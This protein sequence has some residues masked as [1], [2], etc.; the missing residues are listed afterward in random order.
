MKTLRLI[1]VALL[2]LI[3]TGPGIAHAQTLASPNVTAPLSEDGEQPGG[4]GDADDTGAGDTA[5]D[6]G[7]AGDGDTADDTGD[8]DDTGGSNTGDTGGNSGTNNQ[9]P[10]PPPLSLYELELS[11]RSTDSFGSWGGELPSTMEGNGYRLVGG[12]G[13]RGGQI[14][15]LLCATLSNGRLYWQNQPD[16][17][18]SVIGVINW[19]SSDPGVASVNTQGVVTALADG[20]VTITASAQGKSAEFY[21]RVFGQAGAYVT[22]A[23][24]CYEDGE[25]YGTTY[26]EYDTIDGSSTQFYLRVY[27]S[28][29]TTECN[30][31]SAE[32]F[33][34]ITATH[35]WSLSTAELGYIN[36]ATGNFIPQRDGQARIY[37]T[38][39][40]GDPAIS[41]G[42]VVDTVY[43]SVNTGE[44]EDGNMPSSN[45]TIRVV[46]QEDEAIEAR[47]PVSLTVAQLQAIQ[48]VQRTYTLTRS[49]QKHVTDSAT[50]IDLAELLASQNIAVEDIAHF[51]LAANDGANPG[52]I[53]ADFLFGHA[54]YYFPLIEW[55]STNEAVAV[56][57]ML[58][59]ADSWH[60]GG[61]PDEDY[62]SLNSGTCLRL[63]FG[64]TGLADDSTSWSI[65]YIHTLTVVLNG[66]P[67]Y[68]PGDDDG[69]GNGEG[70]GPGNGED[71]TGD[72]DDGEDGD[73]D[74]DDGQDG[75]GKAADDNSANEAGSNQDEQESDDPAAPTGDDDSGN[76]DPARQESPNA[77]EQLS[78]QDSLSGVALHELAGQQDQQQAAA[79]PSGPSEQL[80]DPSVPLA[81]L[82]AA[83]APLPGGSRW[84][85]FE[86]MNKLQTETEALSL[87]NPLE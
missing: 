60:D 32:D 22:A 56:P 58:A 85:V 65:K 61:S 34:T 26:V 80:V 71:D 47:E 59:Y 62:S 8:A 17:P 11:A 16:W 76:R 51:R 78:Q 75:A 33:K 43:V 40:G 10:D 73:G 66:G 64:S 9:D 70:E 25:E 49:N 39:T 46:W 6:T 42:Q 81:S 28:D 15:L 82:A 52:A 13:Q 77:S 21:I 86:M 31:P 20:D 48:N 4:S 55:G 74:K 57:A 37:A 72:K 41:G 19:Q 7:D 18:S 54:R 83:G 23:Q 29:G 38:V 5:D 44:S 68:E 3:M 50:G 53:A 63:L 87:N 35:A 30:A 79:G 36:A 69:T 27:Y 24:I 2:C 84:Q 45:L 67:P 12:I 14:R 1:C